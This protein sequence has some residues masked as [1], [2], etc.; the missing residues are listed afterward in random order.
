MDNLSSLF[1][2]VN[3]QG[4]KVLGT[5]DLELGLDTLRT[6]GLDNGVGLDDSRLN[7]SSSGQFNECLNVGDL[8]GHFGIISFAILKK[9][10]LENVEIFHF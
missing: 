4:V 10:T 6:V 1:F 8:L 3:N 9:E 7:V 5:S 2:V